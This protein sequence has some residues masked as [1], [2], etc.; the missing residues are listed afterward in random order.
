MTAPA[1][2]P[3][4]TERFDFPGAAGQRLSGALDLPGGE[5][6]AHALIAHCFSCTKS[7]LAALHIARA[8]ASAGVAVLR[9]DFTG[10]GLSEGDFAKSTFS[11]DVEDMVAATRAMEDAGRPVRLLIGHSLG[12]AAALAAAA[13]ARS[14]KAVATIGAPCDVGHVTRLFGE[15]LETLLREGEAEVD[16]GG[17]PFR[18]RRSFVDD[19]ASHDQKGRIHRLDRALL[20]MHSPKDA[21]VEIENAT[22]I[23]QAARHPKSFVSLDD[24]DH[25]LTRQADA[26]YVAEVIAAWASRYLAPG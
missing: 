16:I 8:L 1:A 26:R 20:V 9:Y 23:F 3:V 18:V 10:L 22:A 19:L 14:V 7:S 21:V 2:Q 4:R 13:R 24:A 5:V 25:L 6:R 17:R 11:G 12:G 15:R